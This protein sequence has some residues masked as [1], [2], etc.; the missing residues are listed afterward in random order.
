MIPATNSIKPSRYSV[1]AL[2]YVTPCLAAISDIKW[3]SQTNELFLLDQMVMTWELF[4]HYWS[5]VKGIHQSLV[6]SL[7]KGWYCGG[8]VSLLAWTSCCANSWVASD[9]RH[10]GAHSCDIILMGIFKQFYPA[11]FHNC[12]KY[13]VWRVGIKCDWFYCDRYQNYSWISLNR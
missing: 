2:I 10:H 11:A 3:C 4:S 12:M 7:T 9:L 8:F 13:L 6:D 1:I 5:F